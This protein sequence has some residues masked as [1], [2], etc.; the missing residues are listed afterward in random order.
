MD[1]RIDIKNKLIA[2][3]DSKTLKFKDITKEITAVYRKYYY[4]KFSGYTIYFKNNSNYFYSKANVRIFDIIAQINISNR[5]VL[6][7]GKVIEATEVYSIGPNQF[8]IKSA[9][10]LYMSKHVEFKENTP[11]KHS[12]THE[13][14]PNISNKDSALDYYNY[15]RLLA[16]HAE[17]ISDTDEPLYFLAK[18]YSNKTLKQTSILNSYFNGVFEKKAYNR[19]II[20]PFSFNTSQL[21]AVKTALSSNIS[22]IEG[23]PGTGK[24]QTIL[25]LIANILIQN[26]TVAV[27]SNNNT[28]IENVYE[29]LEEASIKY[30]AA[31]LG[32]SM[33]VGQFFDDV[34][35]S[36]I[37]NLL[38]EKPQNH[39][40]SDSMI[41]SLHFDIQAIKR[42]ELELAN[43]R[44][45]L[46]HVQ[47]EYKNFQQIEFERVDK[48]YRMSTSKIHYLYKTLFSQQK[49]NIFKRLIL[50]WFYNYDFIKEDLSNTIYNLEDIIY[51]QK[52]DELNTTIKYLESSIEYLR[53]Q[54]NE[55]KLNELSIS[56]F[57]KHIYNH[58]KW[59]TL[60]YFSNRDYKHDYNRFTKRFPVILSTTQ[61]LV[62]NMPNDYLF[63]YLIIDEASQGDL[64]SSIQAMN[65]ARNVVV[66]GDSKQ[67]EFIEEKRLLDEATK[68]ASKMY[69]PDAYRYD[70]HS[71][72]S[73]VKMAINDVPTTLLREHYRSVP[74]IIEF[75]NQ[76]F[77][78][79]ELI[80]MNKNSGIHFE[81]IKT[82]P[83]NHAR[84]NPYGSGLYNQREIDEVK[85]LLRNQIGKDIG[86]ITP[87]R[88]QADMISKVLNDSNLESDT[89]HRFQ[90]RQKDQIILSFVIN[91]LKEATDETINRLDNFVTDKS[92]LNVAI[93]RAKNKV[94]I[95]VSDQVYH[96]KNNII[97]DLILY[98]EH[99]YGSTITKTS[100]IKSAF[101]YLYEVNKDLTLKL[102]YENS[103]LYTSE[104][105][106]LNVIEEVIK[107]YPKV[108]F[109]M[110][111]R[112][113]KVIDISPA[114]DHYQYLSHPWTHVDFLFY[115]K[116]T[117]ENLFVLEVDGVSFHEQD[118]KQRINDNIKDE[119]LEAGGL[120]VHRFKT[121]QSD[122]VYRLKSILN[123]FDY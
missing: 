94:T 114:Q 54:K 77:Y 109:M 123:E 111:Q 3:K 52:I 9:E 42:K 24:T 22:V 32:S 65:C 99:I 12:S 116:V 14:T 79:G 103:K 87:F 35:N 112:L 98:I 67:L 69:I 118:E 119:A 95:I 31:R 105:L 17:T 41:S 96:S 121:N 30:I 28:A 102:Y 85:N 83:G 29:K 34:D 27:V 78:D 122:E 115:H 50:K 56:V 11:V 92:L 100:K 46:N 89:V 117:K 75:C 59:Q 66:I 2:V 108:G 38:E 53:N 104:L 62:Y 71:I 49:I 81:I 82:L 10:K 93:S 26:K 84:K 4:G 110:H 91:N 15:Y 33:N 57:K 61:S 7:D 1:N 72:L 70:R 21:N 64:L 44:K 97:K 20:V 73:S 68:L 101:D 63:D 39:H 8:I 88:Y 18:Q 5:T 90:G 86:V 80:S 74:D 13:K 25:N 43:L 45:N 37:E 48:F 60:K 36:E 58:Y 47:T 113:S 55:E 120:K 51:I 76:M 6:M 107:D 16:F 106:M 40:I 23:P 19:P